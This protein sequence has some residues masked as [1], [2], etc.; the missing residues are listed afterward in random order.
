MK[1]NKSCKWLSLIML[2]SVITVNKKHHPLMLLQEQKYKT[3]ESKMK[4]QINDAFDSTSSDGES[5]NELDK[6]SG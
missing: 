3:K 6:E 5:D 2:N 1:E 4:N